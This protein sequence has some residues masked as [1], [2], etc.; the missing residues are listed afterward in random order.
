MRAHL[1]MS[2]V[3]A[4]EELVS[5]FAGKSLGRY[6]P[7]TMQTIF[8]D[9][10]FPIIGAGGQR[11]VVSVDA[12]HVGKIDL[13]PEGSANLL[14]EQNYRDWW[15]LRDLLVP[16]V[17]TYADGRLLIM[18]RAKPFY[19]G[20][21]PRGWVRKLAAAQEVMWFVDDAWM[22]QNWGIYDGRVAMLDY[23]QEASR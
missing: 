1:D 14:E 6:R 8:S 5:T 4:L 20:G 13:D 18:R 19:A 10:G 23:A 21:A 15:K 12:A 16:V 3:Y 2:K 22:P 7:H 9:V 11:I 17:G